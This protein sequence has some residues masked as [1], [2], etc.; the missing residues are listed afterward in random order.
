MIGGIFAAFSFS[1]FLFDIIGVY[2]T[3]AVGSW[4]ALAVAY[5]NVLYPLAM[6]WNAKRWNEKILHTKTKNGK[7]N[8]I[9]LSEYL[10]ASQDNYIK[11]K[12][13]I[14]QCFA[15]ENLLFFERCIIFREL[16]IKYFNNININASAACTAGTAVTGT[17]EDEIDICQQNQ[18]KT[19][20]TES[21]QI[22]HFSRAN[23][24]SSRSAISAHISDQKPMFRIKFDYLNDIYGAY[25]KIIEDSIKHD[26]TNIQSLVFLASCLYQ[27]FVSCQG[28]DQ[29]KCA[30]GISH[31]YIANM[32]KCKDDALCLFV[33]FFYN[34]IYVNIS[35]N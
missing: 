22:T 18:T 34:N 4:I 16:I 31:E 17:N 30:F 1:M 14:S 33:I 9:S 11:F 27:Q 29:A 3:S 5:F 25:S 24:L 8:K 35:M 10:D 2:W 12:V 13:F 32:K 23:S 26:E 6:I 21:I 20:S 28:T 7:R 19:A 15:S